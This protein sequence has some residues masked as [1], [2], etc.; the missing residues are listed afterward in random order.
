MSF[1]VVF[2]VFFFK[3]SSLSGTNRESVKKGLFASFL[4]YVRLLLKA[5]RSDADPLHHS[6]LR[7]GAPGPARQAGGE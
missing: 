1:F 2:F 5:L 7:D 3:F 6:P 4:I